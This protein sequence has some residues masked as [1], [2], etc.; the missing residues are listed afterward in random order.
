M[1]FGLELKAAA[2]DAALFRALASSLAGAA[3]WQPQAPACRDCGTGT[4]G[5]C[6]RIVP[7]RIP[8][9]LQPCSDRAPWIR[10]AARQFLPATPAT[11]A[12]LDPW[13][14]V[15]RRWGSDG[16]EPTG[17]HAASGA[18]P[19]HRPSESR[20]FVSLRISLPYLRGHP[21]G[22]RPNFASTLMRYADGSALPSLRPRFRVNA[23]DQWHLPLVDRGLTG[24]HRQS[25]S[26]GLHEWPDMALRAASLLRPGEPTFAD[27]SGANV[28]SYISAG[29][30]RGGVPA[31]VAFEPTPDTFGLL[32]RKPGPEPPQGLLLLIHSSLR[33][34]AGHGCICS[35]ST[36]DA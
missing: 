35:A 34:L 1:A 11:P 25:Y 5:A 36:R 10:N 9:S 30:R 29:L 19:S 12:G 6:C 33:A 23:M 20:T 2:G 3:P 16:A 21:L 18:H 13:E 31:T 14:P 32:Q 22:R 8:V 24:A 27:Q 7:S 4:Q 28:G 26:C 15:A 17:W